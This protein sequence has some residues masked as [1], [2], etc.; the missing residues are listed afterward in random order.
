[1]KEPSN[2]YYESDSDKS[3][4]DFLQDLGSDKFVSPPEV[5]KE[6]VKNQK[7]QEREI[8]AM[9]LQQERN[10]KRELREQKQRDAQQ[11]R[12]DK[13]NSKKTQPQPK[14]EDKENYDIFGATP[15]FF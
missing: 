11:A 10:Y 5:D 14:Q 7:Q 6:Q 1:M 9:V 15:R 4:V 8:K 12:E 13:K 3:E 2:D